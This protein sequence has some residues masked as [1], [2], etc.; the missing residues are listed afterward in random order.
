MAKEEKKEVTP[1]SSP[2]DISV[3]EQMDRLFEDFFGRRFSPWWPSVKWPEIK[4]PTDV[5]VHP[6]VDIFENKD[7]VIV[8]AELPGI[9][10]EDVN[11]NI[12]EN[13]ITL[14][15]EK[16]K[17]EKVE[18]KD[19]Y[20]LE[21]SYGSFSRS[22]RLPSDVQTEKAKATFKDGLLEIRVPKTEEAK[23]KQVKVKIE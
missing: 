20:R 5:E 3:F 14:S 15:G 23:K 18:K 9:A 13:T 17:E 21:R 22:F 7:E 2:K 19:Y 6:S 12:T 1:Y 10:K 16:K 8:K 11:V 4:W